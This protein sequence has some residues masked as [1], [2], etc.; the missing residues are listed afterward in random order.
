[1]DKNDKIAIIAG[2]LG[3]IGIN[4]VKYFYDRNYNIL[5]IDNKKKIF[6][7]KINFVKNSHFIKYYKINLSKSK[8]IKLKFLSIKNEFKKIDVLINCAGIQHV[9]NIESFPEDKWEQIININL[10]SAFYLSKYTLP[11]MKKNRWGRIINIASVHGQVASLNKSAYIA[12]KHGM[13]GLTKAIALET[14]TMPITCNAISPGW[15]NTPLLLKQIKSNSKKNKLSVQ[16]AAKIMLSEKQPNQKF[17]TEQSIASM[18]YY[19]C[20]DEASEMTGSTINIDGGW[21]SQ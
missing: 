21:T 6:F 12:A 15:V 3:G 17:I 4:I 14:A 10:S 9:Q 18:A 5:I 1:M 8:S 7:S 13:I 16:K 20:S 2:G 11:L 19:L